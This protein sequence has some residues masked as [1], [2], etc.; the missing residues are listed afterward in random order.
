MKSFIMIV[1]FCISFVYSF[2]QINI[3]LDGNC[4]E[5]NSAIMSKAI[6]D[7]FGEDSVKRWINNNT[8][9]L[10]TANVDS[11]GHILK[12]E[13]VRTKQE[14]SSNIICS[15]EN[16][17]IKNKVHFFICYAQDPPDIT[18]N[19]IID[20]V[21]EDFK[22]NDNKF[23]SIGFPGE[24]ISLYGYEREKAQNT[25]LSKYDYLLL[26]INKYLTEW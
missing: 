10:F 5:H 15:I 26:Q 17:L 6:I 8:R 9:I 23:I 12:I 14:I 18:K 2:A 13:K 22:N 1:C 3:S 19:H 7:T 25:C 24:L 20:S 16:Y 11:L 4:L 21:R